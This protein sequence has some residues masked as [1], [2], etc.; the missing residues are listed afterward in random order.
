MASVNLTREQQLAVTS[1]GLVMVSAS[2]GSGK[3]HTMLER[4]MH[5][6]ENGVGLDRMLILVYNEANA[7]ELREK[8]RQKLFEKVCETVGDA[9]DMYRKQLDEIAFSTICTIHA[10]C[11][12]AIRKNFEVIGVNPDFDILDEN[13]HKVYMSKALDKTFEEFA[14][15]DVFVDMMS[16]FEVRRSEDNL[17]AN[18][19]RLYERLDVQSN[20]EQ[21]IKNSRECYVS[22]QK[23]DDII[24]GH[25]EHVMKKVEEM[26]DEVMPQLIIDKQDQYINKMQALKEMTPHIKSRNV[27]NIVFKMQEINAIKTRTK[28]GNVDKKAV[29]RCKRSNLAVKKLVDKIDILYRDTALMN[30][31]FAQ[32]KLFADKIIDATLRFKEILDDMKTKDNVLSFGDLEHGAVKLINEG[33]DIGA[34]YD[35]VFV[36]EYQDVN[37]AQEYV[38]SNLVK[39]EAFMVGD[40]KQ[41]IYGFRLSDPEIF[42]ARQRKYEENSKMGEGVAPIL[43]NDNF[44]S[45]NQIL[46][47]VN[48]IFDYA[49]TKDTAGVD[50]KREGRFNEVIDESRREGRVEVHVFQKELGEKQLTK[51]LYKLNEHEDLLSCITAEEQEGLYIAHE[52]ERLMRTQRLT[53]K[54]VERPLQYGDFALL[55]RKRSS[56]ANVIIDVL[57]KKGIPIDDGSF[58]KEDVPAETEFVNMLSVID[59]PRQDYALAG[60][61]LSYLGGY[62]ESELSA[63]VENSREGI[64][65]DKVVKYSKLDNALA[66]KIRST[67]DNLNKYRVKGSYM[68]VKNLVE[69]MVTD[70][71]YDAY[72][73]S[74]SKALANSFDAYIRGIREDSN[75][76]SKYLR[77]YK[78]G[79]VETKSRPEGG[80]KV[81]VSTFHSYK[82]LETPVVFLPNAND[83]PGR[84]LSSD[85]CVDAGG[86]ISMA[87]FDL[88]RRNKYVETVSNKAVHLLIQEKEYKEEMRLLYV[89]LTRAQ[90]IMYITGT[91]NL[92][93]LNFNEEGVDFAFACEGFE[94]EKTIFNYAFTAKAKK[95]L[96]FVPYLHSRKAQIARP[97]DEKPFFE[98]G[99]KRTQYDDEL[100]REIEKVKTFEYPHDE[101]TRLSMKYTVTQINNEGAKDITVTFPTYED[102]GEDNGGVSVAE[103]GTAYHKVMEYIDFAIDNIEDVKSAIDQ[104]VADGVLTREAR[105]LVE[106]RKILTA[107]MNPIIKESAGARCRHEQPF[108][109]YVPAKEVLEGSNSTDKVLVQGVIDLLVEGK[110]KYIVDFKYSS[111]KGEEGKNKYKKQLYLYKM[112]YELS[113]GEKIDK[114][115]LLSLK[116]GESFEL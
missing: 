101:E 42:L 110:K 99:G 54:G 19:M 56:T 95:K 41:S 66:Q 72:L 80:D 31:I 113:F 68:S 53:I 92:D 55:F 58:V 85:L 14:S 17:R 46:Q 115:V 77:E 105:D 39:D 5:L 84:P 75:I 37:G 93:D 76:L 89:A 28:G 112:A 27:D 24:F 11:R 45:D 20:V 57:K 102:D 48:G 114:V 33:V 69:E 90:K 50:Y 78:E 103:I 10:F 61:M 52:I 2:A 65:Y 13:A 60:F 98:M 100:A 29:E 38:I 86:C 64:L 91:V 23:F 36:D 34:D 71:C 22:Q 82:G 18:I 26:I 21:F 79:G 32:N 51:T 97:E 88:E 70:T 73:A 40:V 30:T 67:L 43:F 16:I 87:Y 44:R 111:L 3:T 25:A 107:L 83:K 62:T 59:N 9:A 49:M 1:K 96:D 6:I 4:I 81:Q 104:M 35:Y 7:S 108:M 74:K 94:T 12:T 15:D 106:D 47:F 109:I 8:I 116:T 63:I